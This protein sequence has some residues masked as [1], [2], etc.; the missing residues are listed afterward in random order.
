[1]LTHEKFHEVMDKRHVRPVFLIDIAVPRDVDPEINDHDNAFVYDIDGIQNV[2][3]LNLSRRL[4][5]LPGAEAVVEQEVGSFVQ[6][7][8]GLRIEPI[9]KEVYEH[10]DSLRRQEIHKNLKRF[11]DHEAN[12]LE[13]LTCGIQKKILHRPTEILRQCDPE[14]E[15]GRRTM[16]LIRDLFGLK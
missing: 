5:A 1:I 11:C 3:D 16:E 15:E 8:E 14:T 4:E 6:W 9:V 2:A 12:D 10:F 13:K 7:L